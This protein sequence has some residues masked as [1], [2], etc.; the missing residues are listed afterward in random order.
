MNLKELLSSRRGQF[1]SQV[2]PYLGYVLQSGVAVVFLFLL[3]AFSAWYT[4]ILI[5]VPEGLPIRWIML[6]ILL[7]LTIFSSARTYLK[8]ADVVFLLPQESRMASYFSSAV[9]R[10]IVYKLILLLLAVTILWPL[11]IRSDTDPQGLTFAVLL[12]TG[13][14]LLSGWGSWREQHMVFKPAAAGYRLLRWSVIGLA[15]ASWLWYS[16]VS[17]LIFITLLA[18]AYIAASLVPVRHRVPWERFIQLEKRHAAKVM[19]ILSWFVNVP[20]GEQ[21]VYARKWLSRWGSGI[22]WSKETAYRFLLI[23]S[24]SR[25]ESFGIMLRALALGLVLM[26]I[27]GGQLASAAVYLVTLMIAGLQLSSLRNVHRESFWLMVYP[28]PEGSRSRNEVK[29][30]VQLQLLWAV[31]LL[32][33]LLPQLLSQP[34][35]VLGTGAA[36][37]VLV[38]GFRAAAM[39]KAKEE[40]E[41]DDL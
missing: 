23:K 12:L 30:L 14:K 13:L 36:G 10:G 28:L 3:I 11:Y 5:N 16:P 6:G 2:L 33:P 40:L 37:L 26:I 19:L 20:Q 25:S 22:P 31:L 15:L 35:R 32:L 4:S 9:I 34:V 38:W 41:E 39:R 24:L 7:P 29:L 21:R 8:P 27:T 1:W 17:S 18:A